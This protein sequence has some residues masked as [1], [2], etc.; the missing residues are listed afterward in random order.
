MSHN[1][2]LT[3][4]ERTNNEAAFALMTIE[5][6]RRSYEDGKQ[7]VRTYPDAPC[8]REQQELCAE[9]LKAKIAAEVAM[10]IKSL[11]ADL[12]ERDRITRADITVPL[13]SGCTRLLVL[14]VVAAENMLMKLDELA[15]LTA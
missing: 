11:R 2:H 12:M 1:R 5:Q 10:Y 7:Y 14:P 15:R 9:A 13:S 6:L 3:H 4:A 8:Y